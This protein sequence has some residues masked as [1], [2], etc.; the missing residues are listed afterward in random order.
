MTALSEKTTTIGNETFVLKCTL[1]AFRRIPATLGGFVGVFSNLASADVDGA[2]FIIAAATGKGGDFAEQERIASLMFANG[3]SSALFNDLTAYIQLLQN[4]GR[5]IKKS[6]TE[7]ND[8][9]AGE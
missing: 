3:L 1:D 5:P 9:S 6:G 4:G 8:V 7:A 2:A